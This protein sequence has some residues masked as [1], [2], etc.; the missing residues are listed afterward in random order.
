MS[1]EEVRVRFAPSPTGYLHIGGVRTALFN[2]LFARSSGGKFFLRI[3]DTDR[4]RSRK[5]FEDEILNS[6]RWLG[7]EWDEPML[8]QSARFSIYREKAEELMKRGL[9]YEVTEDGRKAVR[10]RIPK[11]RDSLSFKDLVHGEIKVDLEELD[12]LVIMK[13]DGTPTYNFACVIDDDA[14]GITHI[15]RGD[16]HISNTPKQMLFYEALGFKLPHFAHLPLILG[17]DSAPLSKRHG[18]VAVSAYQKEGFLAEGLLNY[19]AL[20]GWGPGDNQEFFRKGDLVKRFSL[21]RI[22]NTNAMFDN[23]KLRWL[24]GQHIKAMDE[25]VYLNLAL[26]YLRSEKLVGDTISNEQLE[27]ICTLFK[28]RVRTLKDIVIEGEYLLKREYPFRE[29]SIQKHWK[30]EGV[31]GRLGVLAESIEKSGKTSSANDFEALTRDCASRLGIKAAE[32]I[33][34]ARVALTGTHV[35]PGLFDIMAVLGRGEVIRRLKSALDRLN[36]KL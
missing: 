12:D 23:D 4:E 31:A 36:K 18:A 11:D 7:L 35:S 20:L 30:A 25:R 34:P 27:R 3:E 26:N 33:H 14:L 9:A 5:E 2:Y 29:E 16:D 10:F 1:K 6:L 32:L 24:N 19:L 28:D 15:I 21:D 8:H 13:S 17:R 22:N